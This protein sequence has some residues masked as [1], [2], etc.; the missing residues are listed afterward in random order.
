[1]VRIKEKNQSSSSH[2]SMSLIE[3]PH[4]TASNLSSKHQIRIFLLDLIRH[5][6]FI[7]EPSPVRLSV[8][9]A[10]FRS[11]ASSTNSI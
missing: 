6:E 8:N 7:S 9:E 10:S 5:S 3:G 11:A 2:L 4:F 1:M